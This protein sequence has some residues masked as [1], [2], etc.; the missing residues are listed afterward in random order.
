MPLTTITPSQHT[1]ISLVLAPWIGRYLLAGLLVLGI[2]TPVTALTFKTGE[3]LGADGQ[4]HYGASPENK[5]SIIANAQRRDKPAGVVGRDIFV[6]VGDTVTFVPV[7][8]VAQ[9]SA[10]Q[11]LTIVSDAVI[12][13][14]LGIAEITYKDVQAVSALTAQIDL[15]V[16][17]IISNTDLTTLSPEAIADIETFSKTQRISLENLL[18]VN[19]AMQNLPEDEISEIAGE[20]KGLLDEGFTRKVDAFITEVRNTPGGLEALAQY[21]SLEECLAGASASLCNEVDGILNK[22]DM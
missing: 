6:V 10:D 8:R 15:D 19:K 3:V 9:K 17:D 2:G 5:S 16:S 7:D 14:V 11:A 4:L 18:A 12:Q 1:P 13:N 21:N 20:L 22:H